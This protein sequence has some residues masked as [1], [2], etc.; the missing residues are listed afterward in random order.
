MCYTQNTA[1][2]LDSQWYSDGFV[3]QIEK[4]EYIPGQVA[5]LVN[6]MY[7]QDSFIQNPLGDSPRIAVYS[8]LEKFPIYSIAY[9]QR[10]YICL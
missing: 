5:V 7:I 4:L 2:P 9:S 6:T 10:I 1:L 8:N 3:R